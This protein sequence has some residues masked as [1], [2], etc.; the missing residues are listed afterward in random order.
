M[1]DSK[2]VHSQAT[3][4]LRMGIL[5]AVTAVVLCF[6]AAVAFTGHPAQASAAEQVDQAD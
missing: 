5:G 6:G 3:A 4:Q 1:S 2:S